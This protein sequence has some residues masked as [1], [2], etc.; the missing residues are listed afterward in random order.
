VIDGSR[1]DFQALLDGL[2]SHREPQDRL[3]AHRSFRYVLLAILFSLLIALPDLAIVSIREETF[4]RLQRLLEP[5]N[6]FSWSRD[7]MDEQVISANLG[8]PMEDIFRT[9]Q[10]L[11]AVMRWCEI[12]NRRVVGTP[13]LKVPLGTVTLLVMPHAPFS[14]V[15]G[16]LFSYALFMR[17]RERLQSEVA[18]MELRRNEE[19]RAMNDAK[20]VELTTANRK[21]S[22]MQ[23][24]VLAAQKLASIGRL[25]A[26]LAHEIRNPLT[27]IQNAVGVI[28]DELA[29]DSPEFEAVDLINQEILRLNR[30]ITDLLNFANPKPPRL[31]ANSINELLDTWIPRLEQ[32][33]GRKE[34]IIKMK[35]AFGLDEVLVDSDQLYQVVINVIWN[36]RDAVQNQEGG[37]VIEVSTFAETDVSVCV[38]V[39]DNGPGM[40]PVVLQQITEPFYTTKTKGTG[41]GLSV[42]AQLIEGMGARLR[43]DSQPEEGTVVRISLRTVAAPEGAASDSTPYSSRNIS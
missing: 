31:E 24:K 14:F 6:I 9:E 42:V 33:L 36:A 25:S 13:I 5:K 7:R 29:K 11:A 34:V 22:D 28:G 23:A 38:E 4:P 27:V 32:E 40:T 15:W 41:L 1:F 43:I 19:M 12:Q 3:A 21:L 18:E 35:Q 8:K 17:R 2:P 39:R 20:I 30:I 16:S 10:V 26:T 37:G